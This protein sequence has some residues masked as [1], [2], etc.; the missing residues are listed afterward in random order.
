MALGV[1]A[2][3][4]GTISI[5]SSE[6]VAKPRPMPFISDFRT[7]AVGIDDPNSFTG[8]TWGI[9]PMFQFEPHSNLSWTVSFSAGI[10]LPSADTNLQDL[11]PIIVAMPLF[12]TDCQAGPQ[13]AYDSNG[14]IRTLD[15]YNS[16]ISRRPYD[17]DNI[18]YEIRPI[19]KTSDRRTDR[20]MARYEIR[21]ETRDFNTTPAGIAAEN[22][23]LAYLPRRAAEAGLTPGLG[24]LEPG[25]GV[26][27]SPYTHGNGESDD[28]VIDIAGLDPTPAGIQDRTAFWHIVRNNE[29]AVRG[30][31]AQR[32][33]ATADAWQKWVFIG[34]GG[35]FLGALLAT[36]IPA[37]PGGKRES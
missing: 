4:A 26:S 11:P 3:L 5:Y 8:M 27:L 28:V 19:S 33:I 2:V 22:F 7:V 10:H 30:S 9:P 16:Q 36:V 37:H 14:G 24:G 17:G 20:L 15:T 32:W 18:L 29:L 25:F 34:L 13:V 1:L 35:A 31:I 6:V 12:V 23:E 21:C